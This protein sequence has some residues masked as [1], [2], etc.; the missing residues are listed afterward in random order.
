[1]MVAR[2]WGR[3]GN[4]KLLFNRYRVS[5]WDNKKV[6]EMDSNDG[7]NVTIL[8]GTELYIQNA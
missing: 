2:R 6:L 4:G 1:M 3:E 5:V 8:N 7:H